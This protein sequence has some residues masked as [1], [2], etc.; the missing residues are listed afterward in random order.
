MRRAG[1]RS[2]CGTSRLISRAGRSKTRYENLLTAKD[3][4][5]AK[6][7]HPD[8][9]AFAVLCV[10]CVLGGR[11]RLHALTS[12]HRELRPR[13]DRRD[14]RPDHLLPREAARGLARLRPQSRRDVRMLAQVEEVADE[15]P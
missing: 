13:H 4:K 14:V 9:K 3:A 1:W 7:N 11:S 12:P 10:L 2:S 15:L 8:K 6:E 5:D